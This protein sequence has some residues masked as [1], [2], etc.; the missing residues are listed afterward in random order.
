MHCAFHLTDRELSVG[1]LM[2]DINL[3]AV[4]DIL[5]ALGSVYLS[6]ITIM[7]A[8]ELSG[9]YAPSF[10]PGAPALILNIHLSESLSNIQLPLRALFP[11]EHPVELV[12]R[13]MGG[14]LRVDQLELNALAAQ[15]LDQ[16]EAALFVPALRASYAFEPFQNIIARLRAPGGCPWDQKQTHQSLRSDLV[17]EAYEVLA[18]LDANDPQAMREELGDLLLHVVMQAQIAAE[19]GEFNMGDVLNG[20]H[21]KIVRRHPHVFGDYEVNGE[22]DILASWEETKARE[23]QENGLSEAGLL[24]SLNLALPALVQ[25]QQFQTRAARVKFDWPEISGVL[26]KVFEEIEEVGQAKTAEEVYAEIGDLLFAVVNLARWHHVDAESALRQ[27]NQR[28]RRRF[29]YIEQAAR[30]QGRQVSDLSLDE[31]D[32]LWEA[33]KRV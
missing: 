18:A 31:M 5:A 16:T 3:N 32:Q 20:I 29:K 11:A 19:N 30:S 8:Q 25:A 27:A 1:N 22:Q 33:A 7:D 24:D 4:Q 6:Q 13:G 2:P 23:R 15:P 12:R 14:E 10:S 9:Q 26:A 28:F 21:T 17:E